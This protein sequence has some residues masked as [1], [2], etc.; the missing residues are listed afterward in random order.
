MTEQLPFVGVSGSET[1][2]STGSISVMMFYRRD[3]KS[4]EMPM[5]IA[6]KDRQ[7]GAVALGQSDFLQA[8]TLNS[9]LGQW[10]I[11]RHLLPE[12]SCVKLT[13]KRKFSGDWTYKNLHVLV[14]MRKQAAL[15]RVRVP[16]TGH[17][18]A[19]L[20]CGYYEGNFDIIKPEDFDSLGIEV[21]PEFLRFFSTDEDEATFYEEEL[22][23]RETAPLKAP[24]LKTVQT[25]SGKTLVVPQL[26]TKRVVRL[27][28]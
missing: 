3:G 17:A 14:R 10:I 18:D 12:G 6:V 25:A 23:E 2:R 26:G 22:I 24:K 5:H 7:S 19:N 9:N 4:R 8:S 15:R 20:A 11:S 16:F 28:K 1:F 27:R 13:I 21:P